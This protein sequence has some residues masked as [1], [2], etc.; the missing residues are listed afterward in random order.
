MNQRNSKEEEGIGQLGQLF[1]YKRSVKDGSVWRVTLLPGTTLLFINRLLTSPN[2]RPFKH[3]ML[4]SEKG[5]NPKYRTGVYKA[6]IPPPP[7]G[8]LLVPVFP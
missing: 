2:Y 8:S 4:S 1:S 3:R 7:L 5:E 6:K